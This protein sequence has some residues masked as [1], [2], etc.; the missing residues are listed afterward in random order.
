M[1]ADEPSHML[2]PVA[3]GVIDEV[4]D[5]LRT[6]PLRMLKDVR[7]M[8]LEL[9]APPLLELVPDE[10]I[11]LGSEERHED[12]LPLV[13]AGGGYPLLTSLP[14]PLGFD[15]RVELCP[16]LVLERDYDPFFANADA[17]RL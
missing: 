1:L 14:H 4:Y 15:A 2:R 11:L 6:M 9:P 10:P 7:E 12:V 16:G 13:E 8:E 17:A 5:A 3:L